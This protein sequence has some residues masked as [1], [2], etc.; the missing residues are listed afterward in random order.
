MNNAHFHLIVNHLPIVG[1]LIGLLVLISG[2]L[3]NKSDIKLTAF[4]IFIFSAFASALAFFSGEGAEEAI[5]NI[6]G[7]SETLIH[8]HEELAEKFFIVTIILG[9][10]SLIALIAEVKSIKIAKFLVTLILI[11]AITNVVLAKYAGTSGGEIRHSEIRKSTNC[12][13]INNK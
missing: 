10:I 13:S 6:S 4:G 3:L 9:L 8:R 2:L 1:I 5:E 11:I 7:I 12:I